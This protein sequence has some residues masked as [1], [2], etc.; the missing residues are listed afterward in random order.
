[1]SEFADR[2]RAS[3]RAAADP[4]RAPGQQAYMKSAMPFLGVTVPAVRR[5][6]RTEA[7]ALADAASVRE[8]ATQLWDAAT[9]R[10]ERY[11]AMMMLGARNARADLASV[12]LIEHM[13]TTGRWWDFSDDL[14]SRMQEL[15]DRHP[16][17]TAEIARRWSIGEDMWLR[18]I[19]IISQLGRKERVDLDLLDAV[20]TPNLDDPEFFIRKAVGWAL[21]DAAR[22]HPDWVR[23]FAA[24]HPLSSLSRRE[25]LKHVGAR[26][27]D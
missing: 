15:H 26:A 7:R 2:I 17:E 3:L 23:D 16:A 9:H 8:V 19:A 22:T 13:A 27:V 20:I 12:P 24:T 10:E 4:E 14:A 21:R 11:A 5:I 18:R 25:A 6:A 1:M